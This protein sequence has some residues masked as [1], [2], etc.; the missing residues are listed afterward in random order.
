[1]F[2]SK[3]SLDAFFERANS[4]TVYLSDDVGLGAV[5]NFSW[6]RAVSGVCGHDL[7]GVDGR[8]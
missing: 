3:M 7:G 2:L 8:V 5:D 4:G 6:G 1:M